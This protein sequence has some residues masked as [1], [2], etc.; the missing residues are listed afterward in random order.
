MHIFVVSISYS[1]KYRP[2]NLPTSPPI[3]FSFLHPRSTYI[4]T[5]QTE[6]LQNI[7]LLLLHLLMWPIIF[8]ILLIHFL[9]LLIHFAICRNYATL[10]IC[11]VIRLCH[12][13]CSHCHNR[14]L[15]VFKYFLL[16]SLRTSWL[17]ILCEV[18]WCGSLPNW[19]KLWFLVYY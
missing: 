17:Q 18:S 6:D 19:W 4:Q 12:S 3:F 5:C 15:F 2:A 8:F 11:C 16:W 1:S 14:K 13:H 9:A 7:L 10:Y